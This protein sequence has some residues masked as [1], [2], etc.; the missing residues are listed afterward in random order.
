MRFSRVI[1]VLVAGIASAASATDAAVSGIA[2]ADFVAKAR[3][4]TA[5]GDA[6][7]GRAAAGR[8]PALSD[9]AALLVRTGAEYAWNCASRTARAT[10]P[11]QA[12]CA[13]S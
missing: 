6:A 1:P 3:P 5:L 10:Y 11:A 12:C 8:M 4:D 2:L 9:Q 13:S 7:S